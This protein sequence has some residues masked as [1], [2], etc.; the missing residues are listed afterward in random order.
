MRPAVPMRGAPAGENRYTETLRDGQAGLQAH[1][2]RGDERLK[3]G[4]EAPA[5]WRK[6][7]LGH[8]PRLA[9]PE[10]LR[11]HERATSRCFALRLAPGAS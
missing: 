2:K 4:V 11:V 8:R 6:D 9:D 3:G 7:L 10:S 5:L 1:I